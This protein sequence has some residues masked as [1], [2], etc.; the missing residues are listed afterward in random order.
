MSRGLRG[1][2]LPIA[3]ARRPPVRAL[4]YDA[5]RRARASAAPLPP[6]MRP[7]V[8]TAVVLLAVVAGAPRAEADLTVFVGA[9]ASP[10]NRPVRGFSAGLALLVV[11][12]EVEYSDTVADAETGAPGLRT[13]MF[14]VL[15]QTPFTVGGLQF[16]GT[17]GG[18]VYQEE[19][20]G[21]SATD[22]GS[23]AGGGI[24]MSVAGPIRLRIDYRV[25]SLRGSPTEIT[26]Q[27]VYAG[28]N[29]GF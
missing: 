20:G 19:G 26:Y 23:N 3:P 24:K 2:R 5:D 27:R 6:Q 16:Y 29:I 7:L 10:T 11:G 1:E 8:V 13:G 22:L 14:N 12:F 4:W 17:V 9:N 21:L 15:A 28:L 18:G 25:F